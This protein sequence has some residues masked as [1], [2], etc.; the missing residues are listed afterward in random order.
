[1]FVPSCHQEVKKMK[2]VGSDRGNAEK[3]NRNID[4]KDLT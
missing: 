1:M 2:E 4:Y 3:K